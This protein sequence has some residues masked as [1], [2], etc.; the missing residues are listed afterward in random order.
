MNVQDTEFP[1]CSRT[2]CICKTNYKI[3]NSHESTKEKEKSKNII[4]TYQFCT[5]I[6]GS[7]SLKDIPKFFNHKGELLS[8]NSAS[9]Y[10]AQLKIHI[11]I[12]N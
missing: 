5:V 2:E 8:E 1:C 7:L 6:D 10:Y 4:S 12:T 3:H 9:E 11:D